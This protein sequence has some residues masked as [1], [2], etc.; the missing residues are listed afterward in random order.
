MGVEVGEHLLVE[1][2]V[3]RPRAKHQDDEHPDHRQREQVSHFLEARRRRL[4][5]DLGLGGAERLG[6]GVRRL[7]E[8]AGLPQGDDEEVRQRKDRPHP[9]V[10]RRVNREE[11]P[12]DEGDHGVTERPPGARLPVFV[13]TAA[14]VALGDGLEQAA[15]RDEAGRQHDRA[16]DRAEEEVGLE[17]G[18]VDPHDERADET[19][20]RRAER[21]EVPLDAQAVLDR[22]VEQHDD[23]GGRG[24]DRIDRPDLAAAEPQARAVVRQPNLEERP[25]DSPRGEE[26]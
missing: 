25:P 15:A 4:L 16:D 21:D 19:P 22:P 9:E 3:E 1:H 8:R 2:R 24:V 18:P 20:D 6:E 26:Q 13:S 17:E 23:E 7:R 14:A 11:E 5:G 12:R 10:D